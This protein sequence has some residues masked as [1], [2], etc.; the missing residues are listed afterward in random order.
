MPMIKKDNELKPEKRQLFRGLWFLFNVGWYVALSLIV[1]T[2]IGLWL[3]APE[4]LNSRPLCTLIGFVLGTMTAGYGLYRMLRQF[5][6]E[7]KAMDTKKNSINK[8]Q[9]SE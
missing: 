5:I 9:D 8:E 6:N 3:D 7:Q 2:A 4:R 1:P